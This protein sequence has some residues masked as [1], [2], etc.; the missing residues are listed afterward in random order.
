MKIRVISL[1]IA[2]DDI[3]YLAHTCYDKG[4]L[5]G[6]QVISILCILLSQDIILC[7]NILTIE[8]G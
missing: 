1:L 2:F 4:V 6:N 8:L 5:G 3:V 7:F